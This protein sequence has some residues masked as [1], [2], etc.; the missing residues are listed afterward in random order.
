MGPEAEPEPVLPGPGALLLTGARLADG[1]TVDVRLSGDRIEAVGT[2][3]SLRAAE[4]LDLSG[5]LLL[6]APVEPHAHLD[7]ALTAGSGAPAGSGGAASSGV[8]AGEAEEDLR[9]RITEAALT[10]LGYGSTAVRTH[11]LVSAATGLTRLDA[12]LAAA[13]DLRGLM[14]LQIIAMPD[15]SPNLTGDRGREERALLRQA[16]R[17]GAHALGGRPGAA[18]APQEALA[19]LLE[20]AGTCD[21]PLDLHLDGPRL[22]SSGGPRL[23]S[24]LP[25]GSVLT[26]AGPLPPPAVS[27]LADAAAPGS[28]ATGTGSRFGIVVLPQGGCC[29]GPSGPGGF[30]AA[31]AR[32]LAESGLPLAAGSGALRDAARPVGR[33]D[34]I[35]AAFLLAAATGLSARAAYDTVA[36]AARAILGLPGCAV[37]PG[38]P[39]D[40][41]ALRGDCLDAALSGGHSRVVLHAGRVV[42]RTSAVREYADTTTAAVPRQVRP[43][44]PA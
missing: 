19:A 36:P 40:L 43:L 32:R 31:T 20:L 42:S 10:H 39:A 4:R 17:A 25:P 34:P 30:D 14:D 9:R 35:E 44:G 8:P 41:L 26:L 6:P 2:A 28:A 16:A 15:P 3:G 21:L 13:R 24:S 11:V 22:L 27:T 18:P 7:E 23:L 38:R 33:A 37:E 29:V 1:R 12:A 5:Y